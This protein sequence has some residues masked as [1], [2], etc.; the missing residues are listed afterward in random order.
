MRLLRGSTSP[1]TSSTDAPL[2]RVVTCGGDYL[3]DEGGY[4][5]NIVVTAVPRGPA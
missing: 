3:R 1:K 2:L 4:Q 5:D